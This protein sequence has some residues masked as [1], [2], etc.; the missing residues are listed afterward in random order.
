MHMLEF[1]NLIKYKKIQDLFPGNI[2]ENSEFKCQICG[3][4][5]STFHSNHLKT[6]NITKNDYIKK[7][8]FPNRYHEQKYILDMIIYKIYSLYISNTKKWIYLDSMSRSYITVQERKFHKGDVFRHLKGDNTL[9][10][11]P[12]EKYVKWMIFDID[13]YYSILDAQEVAFSIKHFLQGYIPP[14]QIHIT[15]SG[16]KG[17]H[18]ELFFNKF[19][20]IS[21]LI[22]VFSI[23]LNEICIEQFEG[24]N[25]ELRPEEKGVNGKGIK[26]PCGINHA[27]EDE[28]K[29]YCA[30][31][32]GLFEEVENEVEYIL[33]IEKTDHKIIDQIIEDYKFIDK[34]QYGD[35]YLY[36][37]KKVKHKDNNGDG[38]TSLK[39]EEMFIN[40]DICVENYNH[41]TIQKYLKEGLSQL[42]TRHD[43]S[44]LIAIY[45]KDKGYSR[46]ENEKK[47]LEWS[48]K[49]VEKGMSKSSN[50]EIMREIKNISNY[51][52]N[53]KNNCHLSR[54]KKDVCITKSDL[55]LFEQLNKNSLGTGKR[56]INHQKILYALI[57]HSKR[58][59]EDNGQF[60]MTY[61]QI[62][63]STGIGSRNT[64]CKCITDLHEW[65]YITIISRNK[66]S[67]ENTKRNKA[68]VYCINQKN[69]ELD[70]NIFK[71]CNN[72]DL[73]DNCFLCMLKKCYNTEDLN[74]VVTRRIK[75]KIKK[76]NDDNCI[77]NNESI[78]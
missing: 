45:L 52:Y 44:F 15:Y 42:G 67:S 20:A 32:N 57:V 68:N 72:K 69:V 62:Q 71:L 31:M 10:I 66:K 8:G 9:G 56:V 19:V 30:F 61:T 28:S 21:D 55:L 76:L 39:S 63:E 77:L 40:K 26:L 34:I 41:I 37:T 65:G 3:K 58:Y 47:L 11:F 2:N 7:Y 75:D 46:E 53:P 36:N 33:N 17:Y 59:K 25:V 23:V 48:I 38:N 27:N 50:V 13:A 24:V 43:I 16:N 4:E 74:K 14:E 73:C 1:L 18:I 60:Y 22:E 51:V 35:K 12:F 64:I 6:H 5:M 49:Q 54:L 29:N 78:D 70:S